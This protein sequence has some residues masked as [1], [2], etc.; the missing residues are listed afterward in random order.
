MAIASCIWIGI[1][2][3]A[4]DI[5]VGAVGSHRRSRQVFCGRLAALQNLRTAVNEQL[6]AAEPGDLEPGDPEP[7]DL[8]PEWHDADASTIIGAGLLSDLVRQRSPVEEVILVLPPWDAA[9][10]AVSREAPSKAPLEAPL[11]VPLEVTLDHARGFI[12]RIAMSSA[13]ARAVMSPPESIG[14]TI[15][16]QTMA[17]RTALGAGLQALTETWVHV[18]QSSWLDQRLQ[19]NVMH[20]AEWLSERAV[21]KC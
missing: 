17:A 3:L 5:A 14:M 8:E 1:E 19:L 9:H 18:E 20:S 6:V 10:H 4:T 12:E 16:S 11:A 13:A 2:Y 15:L 21:R 7:G